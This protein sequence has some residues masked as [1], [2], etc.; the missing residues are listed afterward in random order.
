M[1]AVRIFRFYGLTETALRERLADVLHLPQ[2]SAEIAADG[3]DI[4]LR[5]DSDD[6]ALCPYC[7]IDS[8]LA[9]APGCQVTEDFLKK[10]KKYWF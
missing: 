6:T 8:V 2:L 7:G 5:L 4:T 1:G 10:M 3:W 9:D